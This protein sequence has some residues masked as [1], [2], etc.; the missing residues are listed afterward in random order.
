LVQAA[1]AAISNRERIFFRGRT[2]V[3]PKPTA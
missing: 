2:S 1:V 3:M